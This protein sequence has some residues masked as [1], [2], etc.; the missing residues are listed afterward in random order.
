MAG[1]DPGH[2]GGEP[3]EIVAIE[4]VKLRAHWRRP[5]SRATLVHMRGDFRIIWTACSMKQ[6]TPLM[7]RRI[8]AIVPKNLQKPADRDLDRIGGPRDAAAEQDS[9]SPQH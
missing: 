1:F 6:S 2:A 8:P 9:N 3:D 7:K 5:R 4:R